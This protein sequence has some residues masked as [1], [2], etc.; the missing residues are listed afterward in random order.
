MAR[1]QVGGKTR[2][3]QAQGA[4]FAHGARA[5]STLSIAGTTD[6]RI[7]TWPGIEMQRPS[8]T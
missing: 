1:I 2:D 3:V 5:L 8:L 6:A 7:R 4:A